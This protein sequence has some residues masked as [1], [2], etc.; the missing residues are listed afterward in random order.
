MG[1]P[2]DNKSDAPP[3]PGI[4][5]GDNKSSNSDKQRCRRHGSRK[6]TMTPGRPVTRQP[7]LESKCEELKGHI[8]DCSDARQSDIFVKTT[9]ELAEY[10]G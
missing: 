9:K 6:P 10:V 3:N 2:K 8:Y 1:P 5:T 4:T 7:K